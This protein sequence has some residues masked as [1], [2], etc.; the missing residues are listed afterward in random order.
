MLQK[1]SINE[2]GKSMV[3]A[4]SVFSVFHLSFKII[5]GVLRLSMVILS[6]GLRPALAF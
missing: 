3:A 1:K 6:E 5:V 4:T 2:K